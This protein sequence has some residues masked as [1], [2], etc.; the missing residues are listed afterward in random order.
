LLAAYAREPS[1]IGKAFTT[2]KI[3]NY[4]LNYPRY[5]AQGQMDVFKFLSLC[6][7]MGVEGASLH[8]RNLESTQPDYLK[9]IRRA[10]LDQGLA[11]AQFT[12][13][14]DFGK[15]SERHEEEIAKAREAIRVAMFLGS[16]VLRVFAG[17]PPSEA[18]RQSAFERAARSVR[19]VCEEAAQ[20]GLPIGLQNHNHGALVRTGDEVV[21]FLKLVDHPNLTF[22]LDTGQFAGSRGASAKPPPDLRDADYL[23]SIRQTTSLARYVRVK[24]YNPRPDGSEPFLDYDKIFDILRSV[25]YAGYLDI[26]YEPGTG[27]GGPGE[28]PRTAIP[29]V[30]AFLRAKIR[31]DDNR[32]AAAKPASIA[33]YTNLANEKYFAGAE[34]RTETSLAFLEGPAVD[35]GGQVYFTNIPA[36]QILRWD[37]KGRRLTVFRDKSNG[38]NGLRFDRQGRLVTCEGGGRVTRTDLKTGQLTVLAERYEGK[39]LGAPNDLALDA[40]GRIYFTSRLSNR[41]PKAGNVNA[42]YRIDPIGTLARILAWPAIDMPN[43]I[44]TSPDDRTLYLIDA[45]GREN[46]ARRIRA[47]DLRPD[48]TAGNERLLYDFY[49]GRSGDGMAIDAEGNLYVAAGL[50]RRRGNSETL[51]TRPGV[52]VI[53]PQGKLVAFVETPEDTIT[54]CT[55]G[56]PDLRTLYVTC[57]KLLLSMRTQI[58]GKAVYRPEE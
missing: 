53:S 28:D 22:V 9:R 26:V 44:V 48:G 19:R 3:S 32:P 12:V 25:H 39:P 52:H 18:D 46:G 14:T 27:T 13:S 37:P 35:R 42:V 33:R 6:R 58:P 50:H 10:Y 34:A 17:S 43:G 21:R 1:D 54:N 5:F 36:E 47:Y 4:S 11:V 30:V 51:D 56:G 2:M 15:P 16:P 20:V 45:D 8:V 49:P 57:G 55:F 23:Q 38:A 41:D 24:F 7:E 31:M 29:R 40:Q